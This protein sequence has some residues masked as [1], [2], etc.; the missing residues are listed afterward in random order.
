VER[1]PT[2]F[3]HPTG[4]YTLFFAEMWERFSSYWIQ[5]LLL[6]YMIKGFLKYGD[7]DAIAVMGAYG[8]LVY[9]IS[10]FGGRIADRVLGAAAAIPVLA[11]IALGRGA[12]CLLLAP[13]LTKGTHVGEEAA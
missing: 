1:Q 6:Y 4:L 8:G 2:L 3:G 10:F 12:L 5:A 13:V 11:R 9:M 7:A